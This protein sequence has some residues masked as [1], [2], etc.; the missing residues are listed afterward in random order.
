V[1]TARPA[2]AEAIGRLH[3][4]SWRR[5]YRGAYSDA[6]LDGDVL[7]DRLAVWS[8]RLQE[9]DPR[10]LTL[11]AETCGALAGF[12]NSYFDEDQGWGTLIDN[13][14]VVHDLQRR[15]VG[16]SLLASAEG[17]VRSRRGHLGLHVW[18]LEQN[19]GGQ[20]FYEAR[21]ATRVERR[22]VS[23]P[24]GLPSRLTGSPWKLRY[25]WRDAGLAAEPTAA[26]AL[27]TA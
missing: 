26:D 15:G 7:A 22:P 25:A 21:G 11:V 23:P 17:A 3:A 19:T 4:D 18:V 13:L 24:G 2:D 8:E 27:D 10:R 14:H 1:R 16:A 12:I 20:R 6:F 9:A 5:H